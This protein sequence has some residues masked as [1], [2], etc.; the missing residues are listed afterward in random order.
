MYATCSQK[1]PTSPP[2]E[3][4]DFGLVSKFGADTKV[5][6]VALL[7]LYKEYSDSAFNLWREGKAQ[8]VAQYV[9][10]GPAAKSALKAFQAAHKE[11]RLWFIRVFMRA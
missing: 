10:E 3:L 4:I 8:T 2:R 11:V 7:K 1:G 9:A 6:Q 5:T